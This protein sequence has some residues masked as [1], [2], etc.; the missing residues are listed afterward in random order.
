[1]LALAAIWLLAACSSGD[2]T[3]VEAMAT[4]IASGAS[5]SGPASCPLTPGQARRA[6]ADFH[7]MM[8]AIA[9]PRCANCHGGLDVFAPSAGQLHGGGQI[10]MKCEVDKEAEAMGLGDGKPVCTNDYSTCGDCHDQVRN[11]QLPPSDRNF[12]GRSPVQICNQFRTIDDANVVRQHVIDDPLV[13]AG[14]LGR[15]GQN[16]APKPPPITHAEFQAAA[17]DW[18][19]LVSHGNKFYEGKDCGCVAPG[20]RLRITDHY[21]DS[22]DAYGVERDL[23]YVADLM[24]DE[25]GDDYTGSGTY[26][27]FI[28][29]RK[30]NCH[31]DMPEDRKVHPLQG[32]FDATASYRETGGGKGMVNYN[33]DTLDWPVDLVPFAMLGAAG[34]AKATADAIDMAHHMGA[35][36]GLMLET[37][38]PKTVIHTHKVDD[39]RGSHMAGCVKSASHDE[40]VTIEVIPGKF[41]P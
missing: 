18:L 26:S 3:P 6:V 20:P 28:V 14:F 5:A 17:L 25:D 35:T 19:S 40:E 22:S 32:A 13:L 10:D 31:N 8:P 33:F 11:W 9:S 16:L 21:V 34:D 1:M 7:K 29:T 30:L 15:R 23:T 27:G 2:G 12:A 24:L 4:A 41:R 36:M 38:G 37:T 39:G